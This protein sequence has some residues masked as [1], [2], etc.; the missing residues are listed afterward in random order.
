MFGVLQKPITQYPIL[1]ANSYQT[2]AHL[3]LDSQS[4]STIPAPLSNKINL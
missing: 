4:F 1:R 2:V 3:V